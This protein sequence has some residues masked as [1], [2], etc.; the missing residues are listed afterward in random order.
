M[1]FVTYDIHGQ[2]STDRHQSDQCDEQANSLPVGSSVTL[3]GVLIDNTLNTA[4]SYVKIYNNSGP[5]P[6]TTAPDMVL[7]APAQNTIAYTFASG[8]A[9]SNFSFACVTTPGTA[10]AVGPTNAV[11]VSC[12][13]H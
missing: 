6:G 9:F 10:G 4:K 3:D 1:A 13:T 2:R 8:V 12:L 7:V 5:S 11:V